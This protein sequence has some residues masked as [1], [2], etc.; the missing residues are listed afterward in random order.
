MKYLQEIKTAPRNPQFNLSYNNSLLFGK[1][2]MN[3][4]AKVYRSTFPSWYFFKDLDLKSQMPIEMLAGNFVH[5]LLQIH[6][7]GVGQ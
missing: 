4:M 6:P 5:Y 1:Y 3:L 2:P 7:G